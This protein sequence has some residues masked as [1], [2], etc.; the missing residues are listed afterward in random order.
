MARRKKTELAPAE[1]VQP[2]PQPEPTPEIQPA[3]PQ[4]PVEPPPAEPVPAT[5]STVIDESAGLKPEDI[6]STP[7][8]L[9]VAADAKLSPADILR[10]AAKQRK[11]YTPVPPRLPSEVKL[12]NGI[13]IRNN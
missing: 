5:P 8:A 4:A 13:V 12:P 11:T 9:M 3:A 1:G 2:A 10:L 6:P 7:P